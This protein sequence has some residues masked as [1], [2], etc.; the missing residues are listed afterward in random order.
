MK[1]APPTAEERAALLA[2]HAHRFPQMLIK[3]VIGDGGEPVALPFVIGNPSGACRAPEGTK[4][5]STW[6]D[7]VGATLRGGRLDGAAEKLAEDC[8][9]WPGKETRAEWF[10]RWP[11]LK[12]GVGDAVCDKIGADAS[13][14]QELKEAE[15][16]PSISAILATHPQACC[17]ALRGRGGNIALAIGA[18]SAPTWRLL[19]DEIKKPDSDAWQI[20]RDASTDLVLGAAQLDDKPV[21]P[22]LVFDRLPGLVSLVYF[23]VAKLAGAAA[24]YELGEL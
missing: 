15:R 12:G 14:L 7:F 23:T 19:Q 2:Q 17:R 16:P 13:I 6:S 8:V 1:T 3:K 22:G 24:E 11:A 20:V 5:T 4:T 21:L 9:L 10:A 18:P